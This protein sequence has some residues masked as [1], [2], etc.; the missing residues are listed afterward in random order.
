[1]NGAQLYD[2][3]FPVVTRESAWRPRLISQLVAGL[4]VTT[5][6]PGEASSSG[7]VILDV[8]AGTGKQALAIADAAP[9][10]REIGRASCRERVLISVVGVSLK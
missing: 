10:A 3:L 9:H 2:L 4:P 5:T 1:M 8:G 7:P 6:P